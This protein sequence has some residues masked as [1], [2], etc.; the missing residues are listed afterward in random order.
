MEKKPA[1][2]CQF[3]PA[4]HENTQAFWR[5]TLLPFFLKET[6]HFGCAFFFQNTFL[7]NS[8]RMESLWRKP[9]ISSFL[10]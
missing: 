7:D 4:F 5:K 1:Y 6:F 10:V 8:F 9:A 2:F 3:T